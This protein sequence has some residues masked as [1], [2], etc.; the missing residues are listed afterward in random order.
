MALRICEHCG[1]AYLDDG[2]ERETA[3]CLSC[4]SYIDDLYM[5]AWS[6]LRDWMSEGGRRREITAQQLA[7]HLRVDVKSIE[8]LVK[9][10]KIQ[11]KTSSDENGKK[12]K[13]AKDLDVLRK[14]RKG[15]RRDSKYSRRS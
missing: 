11:T 1:N 5:H 13:A 7:A 3:I 15:L 8:L 14:V 6:F 4:S 12:G 10:G 9:M 2:E